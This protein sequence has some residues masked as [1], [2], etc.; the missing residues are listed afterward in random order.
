MLAIEEAVRI[1]EFIALPGSHLS[2]EDAAHIGPEL[3]RLGE[4]GANSA[5]DIET[6]ARDEQSPLHRYFT[7][8]QETAAY[9]HRVEEAR[10][11]GRMVYAKIELA[12]GREIT[13]RA[14]HAVQVKSILVDGDKDAPREPRRYVSCTVI[15]QSP[16]MAEQVIA[17]ALR[18]LQSW[19]ARHE[20]YRALYPDFAVKYQPLFEALDR[21][22]AVQPPLELAG[23]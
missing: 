14:F 19:R 13:T 5:E 10:L 23:G 22:L 21:V 4:A 8:D 1:K 11:L 12:D 6:A 17:D 18:Q 2:D 9:K 15:W 16:D 7:W 20:Q 3:L